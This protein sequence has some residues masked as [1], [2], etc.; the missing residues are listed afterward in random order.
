MVI[1][2]KEKDNL[3]IVI[4]SLEKIISKLEDGCERDINDARELSKYQWDY[5]AEMDEF[6][7]AQSMSIID[8][9]ATLSNNKIRRLRQLL[10]A[11]KS[12][13]FGKI[14][15]SFDEDDKDEYYVGVTAIDTDK[16]INLIDW[17][18][19]LA[20][21][22]YNAKIGKTSYKAPMGKVDCNLDR[23]KQIKIRNGKIERII[24]SDVHIDDDVLQ[25]VLSKSSNEKM[26]NIVSTIQEEQNDVIRNIKDKII[27]VQGS[28]GSG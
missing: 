10:N 28:A 13:Y 16:G 9:H 3:D 20:S 24:E 7:L 23:R 26:K 19:P 6:E 11:I 14:N 5:K 18:C 15:V 17:R 22:F 25:E 8:K 1:D 27:I 2:Q 21:V 12:P 4:K